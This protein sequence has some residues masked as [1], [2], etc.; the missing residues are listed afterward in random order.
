MHCAHMIHPMMYRD[1][2]DSSS[3]PSQ[4]CGAIGE[5]GTI[6]VLFLV[7]QS[8]VVVARRLC[9]LAPVWT[10]RCKRLPATLPP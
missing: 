5:S 3:I 8:P 6:R 7:V 1:V 2:A 10:P 9:R 4:Y